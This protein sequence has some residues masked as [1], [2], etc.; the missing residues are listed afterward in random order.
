MKFT[1]KEGLCH[2][3]KLSKERVQSVDDVLTIGQEIPVKLMEVDRQGRLNLSYVDALFPDEDNGKKPLTINPTIETIET[4]EMIEMTEN[5]I[6][7]K[8]YKN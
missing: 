6:K 8:E 4:T 2:I 3:S 1:C 5:L 7:K